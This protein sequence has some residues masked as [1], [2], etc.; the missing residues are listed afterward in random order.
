MGSLCDLI[1]LRL[2]SVEATNQSGYLEKKNVM[3]KVFSANL[4]RLKRSLGEEREAQK[5]L[6]KLRVHHKHNP[7]QNIR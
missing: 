3:T 2:I 4:E 1:F 5:T 7:K 6:E